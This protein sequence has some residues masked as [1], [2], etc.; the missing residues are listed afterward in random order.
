MLR[1]GDG[2]PF[3][4][5]ESFLEVLVD[6]V[7]ACTA[8]L[9]TTACMED[10]HARAR[11]R[12]HELLQEEHTLECFGESVRAAAA[13]CV[14]V[15]RPRSAPAELVCR[16]TIAAMQH[17]LN[18]A[19]E[20]LKQSA[21]DNAAK[22][23]RGEAA[24]QVELAIGQFFEGHVLPGS[25]WSWSWDVTPARPSFEATARGARFTVDFDLEEDVLWRAPIRIAA[26]APGIVLDLPRRRWL[27]KP[28]LTPMLL[29]RYMLVGARGDLEGWRFEIQE[30]A[31]AA[32]GWRITLPREGEG[33]ATTFDR[34]G[35]AIAVAPIA[36]SQIAALVGAIERQIGARL[37]ARHVRT[38]LLDGVIVSQIEDTT[39][40]ARAL[41]DAIGP[42]VREIR[43]RSRV[44]GEL[45]LKRD[46]AA[47]VREELFVSRLQLAACYASLPPQYRHL[48]DAIGVGGAMTGAQDQHDPGAAAELPPHAGP[49]PIPQPGSPQPAGPQPAGLQPE[50]PQPPPIPRRTSTHTPTL[51][52]KSL[53][54]VAIQSAA[55]T[56][57][58]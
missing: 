18:H 15:D 37:C 40:A 12:H 41:L 21:E 56:A 50:S 47:G 35:R 39:A 2:T 45:S 8:M 25:A 55:P 16:R 23:G 57:M 29:D 11:K 43:T 54:A 28:T 17:A 13:V 26:L 22:L 48:L 58:P 19:R 27:G 5:D 10:R 42:I 44:P 31:G 53:R 14:P 6:A 3:P 32:A 9:T 51:P 49:P 33:S 46:V 20:Q 24:Q 1:F 34:R 7:G 52:V 4:L 38:V 36:L 30:R